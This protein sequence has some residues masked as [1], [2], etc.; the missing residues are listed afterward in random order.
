MFEQLLKLY[1]TYMITGVTSPMPHFVGPPGSGKSTVFKQLA[2]MLGVNLHIVNVSRI[3]P[4]GLE[5]LELPDSDRNALTLLISE[6]W[7]KAKE[8]DIYLFDEFLRGFPE[9]YN[10]LLDIF[11]S[12]SFTNGSII[13]M[14]YFLG[15]TSIWVLVAMYFQDGTGHT[16]LEAGLVGVPSALL[17]ALASHWAGSRVIQ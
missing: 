15:M 1:Y 9:V 14:L 12:R 4:L 11:T 10:G 16:A 7:T 5:G 13:V 8:G 17:A 2:D 6:M 3:S